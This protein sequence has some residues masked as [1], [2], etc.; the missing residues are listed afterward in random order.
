MDW[1]AI[2]ISYPILFKLNLDLFTS[3]CKRGCCSFS[4]FLK[5]HNIFFSLWLTRSVVWSLAVFVIR[6]LALWMNAKRP[7]CLACPSQA[8]SA[9]T[10]FNCSDSLLF[11]ENVD[12]AAFFRDCRKIWI[13]KK[14]TIHFIVLHQLSDV[15]LW[16]W[17]NL[18]CLRS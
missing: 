17:A 15:V 13:H 2:I 9:S 1:V 6:S 8:T 10:S 18:I 4:W 12:L 11:S 5:L 14:H 7:C 16:N 3:I